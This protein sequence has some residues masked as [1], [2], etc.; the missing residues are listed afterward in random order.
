MKMDIE[1]YELNALKGGEEF[2]KNID[3]RYIQM[4]FW[5]AE[6]RLQIKKLLSGYGFLLFKDIAGKQRIGKDDLRKL[7]RNADIY[8]I[9][10]RY[11]Q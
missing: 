1:G 2:L 7:D 3:V 9:Q 8:F 11:L 5:S 4:E 10:A 6:I